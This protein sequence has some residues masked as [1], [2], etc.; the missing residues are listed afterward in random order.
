MS[1][2]FGEIDYYDF[3]RFF[4]DEFKLKLPQSNRNLSK[5]HHRKIV[6]NRINRFLKYKTTSSHFYEKVQLFK[7]SL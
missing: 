7:Q 4:Y 3:T 2:C 6:Q 5:V 1:F